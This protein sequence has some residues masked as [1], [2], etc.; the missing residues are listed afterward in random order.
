MPWS[1]GLAAV[2]P[3]IPMLILERDFGIRWISRAAIQELRL[4]PDMLIGRSW[5]DLFPESRSR[6]A[7]HE[8][9]CRGERNAIDLPCIP[10][11]LGCGTQYFSLRL[12]P[13]RAAD[14]SVESILGLEED[15][16]ARVA[17]E[18]ALRASEERFRAI[19]TQSRDMVII[20]SAD[21]TVTFESEA[22][23]HIW[24]HVER[25][26]QSFQFLTTCTRRIGHAPMNFLSGSSQIL[27]SVWSRTSRYV[28]IIAV[29][30]PHSDRAGLGRKQQR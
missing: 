20:S 9:L 12:R 24:E 6:R 3:R 5:Y 25:R 14:G 22:V 1:Y 11:S 30:N 29:T 28:R 27:P 4:Q 17:A 26:G 19:S 21:G 10:L 7:L 8:A 13:L 18:Q 2:D 16:T 23:E 15:V